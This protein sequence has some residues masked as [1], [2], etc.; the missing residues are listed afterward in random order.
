LQT[1]HRV[2]RGERFG[3][4]KFGSRMEIYLPREVEIKIRLRDKVRA[5]ESILGEFKNAR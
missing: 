3:I 2:Q 1:G 5:G 4:I